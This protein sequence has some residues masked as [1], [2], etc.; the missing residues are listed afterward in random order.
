ME[1]KVN[2]TLLKE[3]A[4][5]GHALAIMYSSSIGST[6]SKEPSRFCV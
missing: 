3:T 1:K 4:S 5:L 6:T 2:I